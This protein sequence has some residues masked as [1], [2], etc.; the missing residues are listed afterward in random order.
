MDRLDTNI[1]GMMHIPSPKHGFEDWEKSKDVD[2]PTWV[3]KIGERYRRPMKIGMDGP[4]F[5]A[6][7]RCV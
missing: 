2:F 7:N 6:A 4:N 1:P 5:W 3:E